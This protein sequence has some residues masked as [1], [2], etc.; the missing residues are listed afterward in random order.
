MEQRELELTIYTTL[1]S[2]LRGSFQ[3]DNFRSSLIFNIKTAR[4][5]QT[6]VIKVFRWFMTSRQSF[7]P[8]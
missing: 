2:L 6:Y 3:I 1:F 7:V 8:Y 5:Q 4:V